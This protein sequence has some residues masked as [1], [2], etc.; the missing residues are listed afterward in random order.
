VLAEGIETDEVWQRL[1]AMSCDEGQ[2]YLLARP[3]PA[4]ELTSWVVAHVIGEPLT[5]N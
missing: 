1:R 2:G 4:E 5:T 3:M